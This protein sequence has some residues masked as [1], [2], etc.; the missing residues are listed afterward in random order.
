MEIEYKCK[1]YKI[2]YIHERI[3]KNG[4]IQTKGGTTIAFIGDIESPISTGF[5]FVS[6]KDNY[7]KKL[8]RIIATGRL[9]KSLGLSR[10]IIKDCK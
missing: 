2:K 4:V 7:S 9:L 5:S 10:D 6:K 8:G 1:T 3:I